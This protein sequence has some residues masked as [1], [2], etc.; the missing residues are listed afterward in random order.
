M[1]MNNSNRTRNSLYLNSFN[2][3]TIIS[4]T[5]H[6]KLNVTDYIKSNKTKKD[7]DGTKIH[8]DDTNFE[9][10]KKLQTHDTI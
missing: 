10:K 8:E 1:N 5:Q 9:N 6:R 3:I 4:I 2:K 7:L